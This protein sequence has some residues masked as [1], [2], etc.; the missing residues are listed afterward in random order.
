[1]KRN[2]LRDL[3][4]F[5]LAVAAA[6]SLGCSQ[7]FTDIVAT[8]TEAVGAWD[9]ANAQANGTQLTADVCMQQMDAADEVSD[10]LLLQLRNKGYDR[11]QLAMYAPDG[12]QSQKQQVTWSTR[13]GKQMQ[14]ASQASDNPCANPHQGG[15]TAEGARRDAGQP[16]EG[17]QPHDPAH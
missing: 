3:C 11:I 15:E 13:N 17:A 16:R 8:N 4:F 6:F 2:P 14:G 12:E 5:A 9:V 10:R 7:P 1:M